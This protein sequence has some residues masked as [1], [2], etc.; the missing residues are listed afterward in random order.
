M[1]RNI[2]NIIEQILGKRLLRRRIGVQSSPGQEAKVQF[3]VADRSLHA[4]DTIP[5]FDAAAGDLSGSSGFRR[6]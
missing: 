5:R 4:T 2:F 1:H 3:L 6:G